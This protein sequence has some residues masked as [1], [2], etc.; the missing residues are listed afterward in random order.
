MIYSHFS[1]AKAALPTQSVRSTKYPDCAWT[2]Q[3][4]FINIHWLSLTARLKRHI[5]ANM[6][7]QQRLLHEDLKFQAD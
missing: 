6:H 2:L 7:D 1:T 3:N 4:P 5:C